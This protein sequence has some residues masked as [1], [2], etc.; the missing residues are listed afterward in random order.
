MEGEWGRYHGGYMIGYNSCLTAGIVRELMLDAVQPN[1]SRGIQSG[2]HAMRSLHAE[3][4]GNGDSSLEEIRLAFPAIG[5][6]RKLA[7]DAECVATATVRNP[8]PAL[9]VE[10]PTTVPAEAV[11]LWTILA[12][13]YPESLENVA[14][15][16]VREGLEPALPGVPVGRF[17][18][19]KTVDRKEI[20]SLHSISSLIREY[21]ERY[22]QTPL[23][24]AVFGPPGSGKSFAVKEVAASVLPGQIEALNFNL[25]QFGDTGDLYDAFHQARDKALTGKIPLIFWDEF[26]THLQ[27]QSLGWLRYFLAPMQDGE[28]Q[29]GQIRHPIGRSMF[30]FA[31][32]TSYSMEA[33]GAN[34]DENERRAVKLPDFV[35]RL[36]GFLNILG[37][38]QQESALGQNADP[39]YII[40]RAIILR[41]DFERFVPQL[42]HHEGN[43]R[44]LSID[45]GV[46]RAFL[47]T[48][49]Y[50]H[51]ARSI[52]AI[53]AM[54]QL[55]GKTSFER[56]SL[57]PEAQLNLHVDGHDFFALMHH[58]ELDKD[59]LEK[60][61]EAFHEMFC[62]ELYAKGWTYGPATREG[63]K[64][65]S[66][67]RPYSQLSEDDKEQNRDNVRDI[68]NK[69][70]SVGYVMLPARSS[71]A[72]AK[73]LSD[74]I[75]KLAE[76]E[77]NRWMQEKLDTGWQYAATT[78]KARKL[79]RRLVSWREL[80]END[81][82]KDR[83]LVRGIPRIIAKAGYTMVKLNQKV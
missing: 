46:L 73:F 77:H 81:K 15:R 11:C 19:L 4:Y 25:S 8:T 62:E 2:I 57:P 79:H 14:E 54:S 32:G 47:L 3:G 41:S 45:Q 63:K 53:L 67:L 21:C 55:A 59:L 64:E 72:P 26:D 56:S 40:R 12:D 5:I 60:L 37:P 42:L 39:Y 44:V 35:S 74:E 38:N 24:I 71:E 70:A 51:G 36:K 29:E 28:F 65:H 58:L 23:S 9:P 61:A 49:E 52:E 78:D 22:Q 69:L 20:E 27:H 83:A 80:S 50:K 33:F 31:G 17:G 10:V 48:R 7:G 68:P 6:A 30:V 82:D 18:K 43:K 13:K 16:I 76:A 75:E 34:L 66:S 1:M